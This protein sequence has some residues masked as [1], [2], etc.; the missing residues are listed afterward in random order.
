M[1]ADTVNVGIVGGGTVG[2]A[3]ARA[4]T[5]HVA[6]VRVFDVLPERRTHTLDDVYKCDLI[7][8]CLPTP[9]RAGSLACNTDYVE[10][11]F[12]QAAAFHADRRYVIRSTVPPGFTKRMAH[13]CPHVCH[14]PEFLTAR[15]ANTDAQMPSRNLVG[16]PWGTDDSVL[17]GP[18]GSANMLY[19]LYRMRWPHVPALVYDSDVTE[20][21]KLATN[22]FFAVKLAY[23]NEVRAYADAIGCNWQ[24]VITA[25][26]RDQRIS[27]SHTQ[28]PGRTVNQDSQEPAYQKTWR[29]W[30]TRSQS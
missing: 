21:V 11:F 14:S 26:L 17:F 1:G 18:D 20:M 16:S 23:W 15:C 3:T 7:M 28:V 8:V 27:P 30:C 25:V 13:F 19:K 4:F 29:R 2:L 5:E 22:G 10:E 9:Q 24:H 6:E 12:S